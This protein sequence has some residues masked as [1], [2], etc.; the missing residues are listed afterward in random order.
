MVAKSSVSSRSFARPKGVRG[1]ACSINFARNDS[2]AMVTLDWLMKIRP[3]DMNR[4][5]R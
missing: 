5:Q 3:R 4:R 2:G 1:I